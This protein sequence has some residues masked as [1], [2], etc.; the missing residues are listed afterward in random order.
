M[1]NTVP[2]NQ[3][4]VTIDSPL[5]A[6]MDLEYTDA[7]LL[8]LDNDSRFL[9]FVPVVGNSDPEGLAASRFIDSL[10]KAAA[11][12][13]GYLEMHP[14]LVA[15]TN[16]AFRASV[17]SNL[18]L[19]SRGLSPKSTHSGGMLNSENCYAEMAELGLCS[20]DPED[21]VPDPNIPIVDVPGYLPATTPEPVE[22]GHQYFAPQILCD[23][24]ILCN[25]GQE[26]RDNDRGPNS[27]TSGK[28][29]TELDQI[30]VD[31]NIREI[32]V[33]YAIIKAKGRKGED[34]Y[35]ELD[36][37]KKEANDRMY[38]CFA[39]AEKLTDNGAHPAP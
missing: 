16:N 9:S 23:W 34:F 5:P 12:W 6:G 24:H 7:T 31:I 15:R 21:S 37:C 29:K 27:G 36:M 28:T 19:R 35:R 11:V 30:C 17:T 13:G 2:Q 25:Q 8:D 22:S 26:P 20:N 39:T 10:G 3:L 33:C 4:C 1:Y 38:A 18:L 32:N 14:G